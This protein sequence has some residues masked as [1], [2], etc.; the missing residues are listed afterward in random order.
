MN[1]QQAVQAAQEAL[2]VRRVFGEPIVVGG[3][4]VIPAAVL[5]GGGGGGS[6]SEQEGGGGFGVKAKPAGVFVV[7][8]DTV[9]WRPA[10]DVNRVVLGGQIVA[11]TAILVLGPVLRRLIRRGRPAHVPALAA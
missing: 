4:T 11:V 10:V 6:K 9:K 5:G 3:V 7:C 1:A 8:R 2:T